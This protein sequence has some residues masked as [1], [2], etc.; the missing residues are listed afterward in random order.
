MFRWRNFTILICAWL[1]PQ[2]GLSQTE[3]QSVGVESFE[4]HG[5]AAAM[6]DFETAF[7]RPECQKSAIMKLNYALTMADLITDTRNQ[8]LNCHAAELLIDVQEDSTIP[9]NLQSVA[10]D[11]ADT[12]IEKCRMVSARM[13]EPEFRA[14]SRRAIDL[15][16]NGRREQAILSWRALVRIR[17]ERVEPQRAL[18]RLLEKTD[19]KAEAER[20]CAAWR[21]LVSQEGADADAS[22][23]D[24]PIWPFATLSGGLLAAAGLTYVLASSTHTDLLAANRRA[25]V[26][27][28]EGDLTRFQQAVAEQNNLTDKMEN[29]QT[30][31]W[32]LLGTGLLAG[33]VGTYLWFD[34]ESVEMAWTG[35][36]VHWRV[37]W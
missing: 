24:Y 22:S 16:K 19:R 37:Q 29:L 30:T 1:A 32:I 23:G 26:A 2:A 3:C 35:S 8:I 4:A 6:Q 21:F 20:R 12:Y 7:E 9:A 11:K 34:Q 27:A 5:A 28:D 25:V 31:T 13:L 17:N 14:A 15:A 33:G 18:C 10:M 36:G